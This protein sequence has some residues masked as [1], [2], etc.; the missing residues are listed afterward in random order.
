[1][2]Q[3]AVDLQLDLGGLRTFRARDHLQRDELDPVVAAQYLVV[4][5]C[6]QILVEYVL[7]AVGEVLEPAKCVVD[8]VVAELETQLPEFHL[9]GMPAGMLAHYELRAI[10][11]D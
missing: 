6:H 9:K 8:R 2:L 4:H 11:P 3:F 1:M 5:Q 10:E 7:L